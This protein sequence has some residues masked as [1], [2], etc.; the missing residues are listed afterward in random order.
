[1]NTIEKILTIIAAFFGI[2]ILGLVFALL[3][4][5]PV[6][7]LWNGCLVGLIVGIQPMSSVWQAFGIMLLFSLLFKSN[8][9]SGSSR[10]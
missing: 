2:L 7:W 9:V 3:M 10:K 5:F 4:A 6:M 1:M 8:S